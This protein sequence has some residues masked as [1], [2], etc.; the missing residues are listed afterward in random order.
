MLLLLSLPGTACRGIA[1]LLITC[2]AVG[3]LPFCRAIRGRG[4]RLSGRTLLF[5]AALPLS[6]LCSLLTVTLRPGLSL[7]MRNVPLGNSRKN[8]SQKQ[9]TSPLDPADLVQKPICILFST[10]LDESSGG[11]GWVRLTLSLS[12]LCDGTVIAPLRWLTIRR[13]RVVPPLGTREGNQA[14]EMLPYR[15][16]Q[17]VRYPIEESRVGEE[18]HCCEKHDDEPACPGCVCRCKP[19][20]KDCQPNQ[21][22]DVG[23]QSGKESTSHTALG[24]TRMHRRSAWRQRL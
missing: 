5:F 4:R 12:S 23:P 16:K 21:Q 9:Q 15:V 1:I 11:L 3:T 20:Y 8:T 10:L 18:D 2:C 17:V 24:I 14:L 19:P 7:E 13:W 6:T 22:P